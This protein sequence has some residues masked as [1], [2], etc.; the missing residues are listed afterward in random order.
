MGTFLAIFIGLTLVG[1]IV[2]G[3]SWCFW[4][5]WCWVLP[6]LWVGGPESITN[7]SWLLFFATTCLVSWIGRLIFGSSS[8]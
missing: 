6:Q 8:K 4:S 3:V 2:A 5:V 7:P 1:A